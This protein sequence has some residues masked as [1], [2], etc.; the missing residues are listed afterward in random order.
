VAQITIEVTDEA[1]HELHAFGERLSGIIINWYSFID[2]NGLIAQTNN[3]E[4][5]HGED[6]DGHVACPRL[7]GLP[8]GGAGLA[9]RS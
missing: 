2:S 5:G 3:G 9:R 1:G 4:A 8:A 7:V 6:H